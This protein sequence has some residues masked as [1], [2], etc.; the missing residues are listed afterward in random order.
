MTFVSGS[1]T[2][3]AL[4][5]A[6]PATGTPFVDN[7]C[8][9]CCRE[10]YELLTTW[11][12]CRSVTLTKNLQGTF[13]MPCHAFF[14]A[15]AMWWELRS[16]QRFMQWRQALFASNSAAALHRACC[17][18]PHGFDLALGSTCCASCTTVGFIMA[19]GTGVQRIQ[20]V[21]SSM[22][23]ILGPMHS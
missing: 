19:L 1:A 2:K 16:I 4:A 9:L 21:M 10:I 15:A 14:V 17:Y 8:Q 7:A 18:V 6:K 22:A 3:L 13:C 11:T 23:W 20:A 12:G 5:P